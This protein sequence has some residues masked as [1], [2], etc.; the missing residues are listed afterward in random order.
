MKACFFMGILLGMPSLFAGEEILAPRQIQLRLEATR[1]SA[2]KYFDEARRSSR[3]EDYSSTT[4]M[5]E[6]SYGLVEG[7][8][9][10]LASTGME[11]SWLHEGA[12][13]KRRG[14]AGTYLGLRQ[15]IPSS[16]YGHSFFSEM[17]V[18][19]PAG[20]SG[21]GDLP[22]G[23]GGIDWLASATYAQSFSPN[24]SGVE[25]E[26]GYLFRNGRPE[27]EWLIGAEFRLGLTPRCNFSLLYNARE[28]KNDSLSEFDPLEYPADS[29]RQ[30]TGLAFHLNL[31]QRLRIE[32]RGESTFR[33]RS[34]F[35]TAGATLGFR[36]IFSRH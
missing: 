13:I 36:W 16:L 20:V 1:L 25:L 18:Y 23:S 11:R 12:E 6:L 28:S 22:L 2:S 5:L 29:G 32:L 30:S 33:G 9:L 4:G 3:D 27:D 21:E 8:T 19:L 31:N 34:Q 14:S 15:K 7:A 26:L 10:I 35:K 24:D 17:G